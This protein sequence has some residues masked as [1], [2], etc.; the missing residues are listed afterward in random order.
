[1]TSTGRKKKKK[2]K[3]KNE[4]DADKSVIEMKIFGALHFSSVPM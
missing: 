4:N 1:M 3:S 2:K